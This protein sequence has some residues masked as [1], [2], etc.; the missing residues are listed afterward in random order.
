MGLGCLVSM[1][2]DIIFVLSLMRFFVREGRAM[3]CTI[4]S[5]VESTNGLSPYHELW[6]GK[7]GRDR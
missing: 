5:Y 1:V 2:R 6:R 7:G 3:Y 4:G